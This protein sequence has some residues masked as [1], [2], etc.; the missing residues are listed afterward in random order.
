MRGLQFWVGFGFSAA[1]LGCAP[2]PSL[3]GKWTWTYD[4]VVS[5]NVFKANGT[6]TIESHSAEGSAHTSIEG[7]YTFDG[8]KLTWSYTGGT[9]TAKVHKNNT[10][11]V[12]THKVGPSTGT[13]IVKI[14]GDTCKVSNDGFRT[15]LTWKKVP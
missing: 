3:V 8:S 6:C 10:D 1:L 13:A 14:S 12:L 15:S 11:R 7:T 4:G 2:Q 5:L 9:S